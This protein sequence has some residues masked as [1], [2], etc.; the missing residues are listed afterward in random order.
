VGLGYQCLDTGAPNRANSIGKAQTCHGMIHERV[1]LSL[2]D[3]K[4]W[5]ICLRLSK[6]PIPDIDCNQ[7][8]KPISA[9]RH[10]PKSISFHAIINYLDNFYERASNTHTSTPVSELAA[11]S[12]S[13]SG[14]WLELSVE[15]PC[16]D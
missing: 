9:S 15:L 10:F 3:F 6:D 16:T 7:R 14:Y 12:I 11:P 4:Y 13:K 5:H 1:R 8:V 2:Q